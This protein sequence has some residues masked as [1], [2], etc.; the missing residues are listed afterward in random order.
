MLRVHTFTHSHI[1]A[2]SQSYYMHVNISLAM[3]NLYVTH[4][5][6]RIYTV[7]ERQTHAERHQSIQI[8][9][10]FCALCIVLSPFA[11]CIVWCRGAHT[12][13]VRIPYSVALFWLHRTRGMLHA[14][15]VAFSMNETYFFF[16]CLVPIRHIHIHSTAHTHKHSKY[17]DMFPLSIC[18]CRV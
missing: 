5:H 12:L 1:L 6:S 15:R 3:A 7:R 17:T 8:D 2:F 16:V 9:F 14:S 4:T 10:V 18:T 11:P 13:Y